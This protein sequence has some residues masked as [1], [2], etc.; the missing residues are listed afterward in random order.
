M[1]ELSFTSIINIRILIELI[2]YIKLTLFISNINILKKHF[3]IVFNNQIL[4]ITCGVYFCY[5]VVP[6]D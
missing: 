5:D 4:K 2:K 1:Y 3:A 6:N